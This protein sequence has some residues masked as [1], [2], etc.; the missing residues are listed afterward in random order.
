MIHKSTR[1]A[2]LLLALFLSLVQFSSVEAGGLSFGGLFG[3]RKPKPTFDHI[4]TPVV[5][6]KELPHCLTGLHKVSLCV[7]REL[8]HS[9]IRLENMETGEIVSISRFQT[10]TGGLTD[11]KS[12]V[13]ILQKA[14]RGGV[15]IGMEQR[16]EAKV[17]KGKY[18]LLSIY[19]NNPILYKGANNG[20][21][22]YEVRN[23]CVTYARDAWFFYS[24]EYYPLPRFHAPADLAAQV[25]KRHPEAKPH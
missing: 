1:K 10:T 20:L 21:G 23:N 6:P 22:H 15:H 9:W 12:N 13:T 18:I 25:L 5:G 24:G 11:P 17:R 2:T 8:S 3:A 16:Y 19:V 7:G 4:Y 14:K